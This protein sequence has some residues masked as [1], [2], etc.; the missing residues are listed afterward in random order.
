M[1][2]NSEAVLYDRCRE[3]GLGDIINKLMIK[4]WTS[5]GVLAFATTY[6]P[7]QPNDDALMEQV[8]NPLLGED[9]AKVPLL[10]R[11][12]FEA[13][14]ATM[15]EIKQRVTGHPDGTTRKM[16]QPELVARRKATEAKVPG[17]K[18]RGELDVSD[19]LIGLF[20][21]M[22]TTQTITFVPLEKA[23]KRELGIEGIKVDPHIVKEGSFLRE[24][25][26]KPTQEVDTSTDLRVELAL[27]RLGLAADMGG[28]LSFHV[29]EELR[30]ALR[31]ATLETP[32][33]GY[34]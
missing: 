2:S 8:I 15:I 12:W 25:P 23:T 20:D 24:V 26:G 6:V 32:P 28:V 29:H 31:E 4:G 3:L 14:S 11:L 33:P 21:H 16:T 10:R 19:D 27:Q 5:Q 1:A 34:G 9:K 17:I 7:N 18:L 13:Y 22:A 30:L